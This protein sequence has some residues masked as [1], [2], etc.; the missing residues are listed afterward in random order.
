MRDSDLGVLRDFVEAF[1]LAADHDSIARLLERDPRH[2]CHDPGDHLL[3]LLG[4][5]VA[6]RHHDGL[7]DFVGVAPDRV[8]VPLDNVAQAFHLGGIRM[9][10]IPHIG[11][12]RDDL[13]QGFF[14]AS[15]DHQR[16]ARFLEGLGI[17]DRVDHVVMLA[18]DGGS[19]LG[20][21]GLDDLARLVE[22]LETPADGFEVDPE[23]PMLQLIP[24]GAEAEIEPAA[25]YVVERG[26]HLRRQARRLT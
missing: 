18:L 16:D 25:A 3:A 5:L 14:S 20:E 24:P 11:M 22:R 9:H 19:I 6:Q 23:A 15:A 7:F 26:C 12:L 1:V 13:E 2:A 4:R 21:H 8:A 10:R 17:T